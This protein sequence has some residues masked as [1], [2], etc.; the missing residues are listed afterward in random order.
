MENDGKRLCFLGMR[1]LLVL[2]GVTSRSQLHTASLRPDFVA[3][4]VAALSEL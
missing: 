2:S 4:S 3:D 1:T